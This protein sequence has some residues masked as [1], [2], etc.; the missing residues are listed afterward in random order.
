MSAKQDPSGRR[1]FLK[2][3]AGA[4]A[5]AS[6]FLAGDARD[7]AGVDHEDRG[8]QPQSS[9]IP[10]HRKIDLRGLHAYAQKSIAAGE[11]IHFFRTSPSRSFRL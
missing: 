3:S 9:T 11:T 7:A 5:G 10:P 6:V 2:Q 1:K 8:S 4:V